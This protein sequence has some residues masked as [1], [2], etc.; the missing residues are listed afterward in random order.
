MKNQCLYKG[1]LTGV[2]TSRYVGLLIYKNF[3]KV[4]MVQQ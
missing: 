2:L 4:K 3:Y 1:S